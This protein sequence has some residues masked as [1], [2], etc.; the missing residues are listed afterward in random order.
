VL[1]ALRDGPRRAER[2]DIRGEEMGAL[3]ACLA[4]VVAL[5]SWLAPSNSARMVTGRLIFDPRTPWKSQTPQELP[6]LPGE[7]SAKSGTMSQDF[8]MHAWSLDGKWLAGNTSDS[9]LQSARCVF[10]EFPNLSQVDCRGGVVTWLNEGRRLLLT[11]TNRKMAWVDIQF[12]ESPTCFFHARRNPQHHFP[13][14]PHNLLRARR[15]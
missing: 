2:P 11:A 4:F 3:L 5:P 13:R 7:L 6:S 1:A 9:N 14:W 15:H 8:I 12:D 10:V